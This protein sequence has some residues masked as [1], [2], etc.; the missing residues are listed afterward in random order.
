MHE[1]I[2]NPKGRPKG[3]KNSTKSS[4]AFDE[5]QHQEFMDQHLAQHKQPGNEQQRRC[6]GKGV[7]HEHPGKTKNVTAGESIVKGQEG[8]VGEFPEETKRRTI[9]ERKPTF[10]QEPVLKANSG[11]QEPSELEVELDYLEGYKY[12]AQT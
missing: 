4:P 12:S 7:T 2:S 5:V 1:I 6:D 8:N 9:V 10:T 11:Q 3:S